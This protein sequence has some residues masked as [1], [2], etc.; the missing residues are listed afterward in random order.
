M[1]AERVMLVEPNA[2]LLEALRPVA[3]QIFSDTFAHNYD[4]QAFETYCDR[5]YKPGGIMSQ[6]FDN[7]DV[8]W[9]V[10]V[11]E[12]APIGYAK[13]TPLRA[14]FETVAEDAL[15]MQQLYVLR[16][17]QGM[18]IAKRL[19]DWALQAARRKGASELFLTVFDH[20]ERAKR[21]Y[22]RLGFVEVGRCTFQ[23]G[24]RIDD[25]RIWR[26]TL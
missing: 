4:E 3:R 24:G 26:L 1:F 13:L 5:A 25:D 21:F 10:A 7:P 17:W 2:S 8:E 19:A 14:P 18:G 11:F 9:R 22:S 23:L 12:G 6:D 15:E 20:N 16:A